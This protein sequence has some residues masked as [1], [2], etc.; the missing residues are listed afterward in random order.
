MVSAWLWQRIAPM[1]TQMPSTGIAA[2]RPPRPR[3]LLVS[4]V[5][6]PFLAALAVAEVLVDPG[7]QA[8]RERYAEVLASA[9]PSRAQRCRHRAVD[10]EDRGRR[11]RRAAPRPRRATRP[12]APAARACAARRR[13]RP[14]GRSS[15]S[16]TRRGRARNR[17]A[18]RHQH[19]ADGAVAADEVL[20]ARCASAASI[21]GAVDR[22]EDDHRVV[23]HAQR[24]GR[25]DPVAVPAGR[26]QLRVA[27]RWCSRRPG[28]R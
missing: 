10:V 1:R 27:S 3:I 14:P 19:Q 7:E 8:A 24:R 17:P 23:L 25:V 5:R 16:S 4:A 11:D 12:S 2:A 20:D 22:V 9:T 28:R 6:L 26:A 21:T 18:M 13:P 15:R